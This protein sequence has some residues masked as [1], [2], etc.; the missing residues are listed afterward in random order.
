M[1]GKH[2]ATYSSSSPTLSLCLLPH[3][4][5]RIAIPSAQFYLSPCRSCL[6]GT[7]ATSLPPTHA[8]ITGLLVNP[9]P[10][11]IHH[12][13]LTQPASL[14][15]SPFHLYSLL[16]HYPPHRLLHT[17]SA[18]VFLSN[19]P[20]AAT[21]ATAAAAATHVNISERRHQIC[22]R[23][24]ALGEPYWCPA[25]DAREA[26][27]WAPPTIYVAGE[28]INNFQLE[29]Q[30][31]IGRAQG[32]GEKGGRRPNGGQGRKRKRRRR[33]RGMDDKVEEFSGGFVSL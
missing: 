29:T 23:R 33:R 27:P 24:S 17:P 31:E 8:S 30:E 13:T 11:Y 19:S 28:L 22:F 18:N 21:A 10:Y 16:P 15:H 7:F 4:R 32:L 3:C 20:I 12:F 6:S 2:D 5:P 25:P 26:R 9:C 14:H 1:T